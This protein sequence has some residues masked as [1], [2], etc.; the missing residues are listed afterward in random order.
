MSKFE[1]GDRV[2]SDNNP[3]GGSGVVLAWDDPRC[4]FSPEEWAGHTAVAWED[5]SVTIVADGA[6]SPDTAV[7][8]DLEAEGPED[9]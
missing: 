6:L 8:W 5:E 7:D 9:S 1:A 2:R 4:L 3:E